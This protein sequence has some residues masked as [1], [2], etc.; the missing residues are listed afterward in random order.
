MGE[1][2]F[3]L[4]FVFGSELDGLDEA[5][6]CQYQLTERFLGLFC[7]FQSLLANLIQL[8]DR[9]FVNMHEQIFGAQ[10]LIIELV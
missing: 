8:F 2:G 4:L 10:G 6:C 5:Q 9:L 1:D 3:E 7:R